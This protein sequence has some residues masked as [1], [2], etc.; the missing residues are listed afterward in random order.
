MKTLKTTLCVLFLFTT[1]LMAQNPF[2]VKSN[3]IIDF[4]ISHDGKMMVYKQLSSDATSTVFIKDLET[5]RVTPI[6]KNSLKDYSEFDASSGVDF[7]S[8][9]VIVFGKEKN[10]VSFNLTDKKYKNLFRLPDDVIFSVKAS[11]DGKR[12]Y[13]SSDE[14]MYSSPTER[15]SITKTNEKRG[16]IISIDIDPKGNAYYTIC[17]KASN[18]KFHILCYDG[19]NKEE[20]ITYKFDNIVTDPY[21]IESTPDKDCFIVAGKNG[22]F[23]VDLTNTKS[24]KL[25]TNEGENRLNKMRLSPDGKTLYYQTIKDKNKI[26]TLSL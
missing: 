25:I 9:N 5:G 15:S 4:N 18:D 14:T 2:T 20:D 24:V 26:I 16:I 10:M 1:T 12:V 13:F 22:V 7:L 11:A 19:L 8:D 21:L 23:K 17:K 3:V 6:Y